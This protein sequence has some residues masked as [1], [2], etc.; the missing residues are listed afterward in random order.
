[1]SIDYRR[2]DDDESGK[3]VKISCNSCSQSTNHK[4]LHNHKISATQ[5]LNA[6]GAMIDWCDNYQILKC[7]GCETV[8]FRH[9]SWFSEDYDY[10]DNECLPREI[11]YPKRNTESIQHQDYSNVPPSLDVLYRETVDSF[12]NGSYILTSAGL[13]ALVEGICA[14]L[15]IADGPVANNNKIVRK[16][17]LEGKINGLHETSILTQKS[18]AA[19]HEH[20]F[21]GNE[22]LH[23]LSQPSTKELRL[24]IEIIDH[25]LKTVFEMPT[26]HSN[27]ERQRG[28]RKGA[29]LD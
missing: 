18:A 19:L 28:K 4:V 13:R 6:H 22:A 20:R 5:D 29:K 11:F 8:T 21:L 10:E 24:A 27:L 7:D 14:E 26:L 9:Q 16:R 25:T 15:K 2:Q 1:M 12:N 17:N 23:E 3:T